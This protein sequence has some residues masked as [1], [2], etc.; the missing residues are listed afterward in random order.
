M[1]GPRD[2]ISLYHLTPGSLPLVVQNIR[3][4]S[5]QLRLRR[6][7]CTRDTRRSFPVEEESWHSTSNNEYACEGFHPSC[8]VLR[9]RFTLPKPRTSTP[10]F[11]AAFNIRLFATTGWQNL[12][13]TWSKRAMAFLTCAASLI[14]SFRSLGQA[15]SWLP[16]F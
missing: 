15:K 16:S 14:G 1:T 9:N 13:S 3:E 4:P 10:N 8:F 5:G 7:A 2:T 6:I 12:V 11:F